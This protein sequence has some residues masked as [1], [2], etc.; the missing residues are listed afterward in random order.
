MFRYLW[1]SI[2]FIYSISISK[3][4]EFKTFT[5]FKNDSISL[6]LDI[7]LLQEKQK[8]KS[9]VFIFIHGGGFSAGVR[10][11]GH[12]LCKYLSN[13]NIAA[14]TV[15]YT[16]YMKDQ[17]FSCDGILTEKV[18]AIQIAANQMWAATNFLIQKADELNL[19]T[20]LIFIGGNSAG[21]E[22][23]LHA[24]YWNRNEMTILDHGLS[25]NFKYAGMAVGSGAIMDLNFITK[26]TAIPSLL[27]HGDEDKLVPYDIAAH[28]YCKPTAPGWLM[29]FGSYSVH[30]HLGELGAYSELYTYSKTGHECS[31]W[32]YERH[33]DYIVNFISCVKNSTKKWNHVILQREE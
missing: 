28:H 12:D 31:S 11:S 17:S 3:A 23:S 10:S 25:S 7:F 6:D 21:A 26:E 30:K 13:N 9:P 24:A 8:Q 15:T 16:L 20:T 29:L 19:D 4:Q 5:Y 2:I 22:T 27:F 33:P 18:K 32:I 1:L 14:A